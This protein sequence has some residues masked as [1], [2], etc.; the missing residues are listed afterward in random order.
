LGSFSVLQ[1]SSGKK[2]YI[3]SDHISG[4]DQLT[5]CKRSSRVAYLQRFPARQLVES[6]CQSEMRAHV[7]LFSEA[8]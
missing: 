2:S 4:V 7:D 3:V 1:S 8:A 6:I 5:G